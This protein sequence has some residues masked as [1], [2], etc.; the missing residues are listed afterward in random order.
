MCMFAY[1][2][3]T[4]NILEIREIYFINLAL[5]PSSD[6]A[7]ISH[8]MTFNPIAFYSM[9]AAKPLIASAFY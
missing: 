5:Y 3:N 8:E 4:E 2:F 9:K 7:N 6:S 1:A